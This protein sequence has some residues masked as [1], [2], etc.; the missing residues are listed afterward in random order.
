MKNKFVLGF[1][2]ISFVVLLSSCA[3]V[4]QADLDAVNA[5]IENAR[6][7]GADVYLP[8]EF[9]ALQDSMNVINQMVEAQKGKLFG[10]YK[11]VSAKI[12]DLNTAAAATKGNVETKKVE[13]KNNIDTLMVQI[14]KLVGEAK[15]LVK[16]APRG[17]E[18]A[19]AVDA[20]KTEIG[21]VETSLTESAAKLQSG[22]L[23]GTLDQLKAGKEKITA[24]IT[25]L[26]D[27]IAKYK[28]K[29]K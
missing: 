24:L 28:G 12:A 11:A 22:D 19:A 2:V 9:A 17:K 6:T 18:G 20:I 23:M 1:V 5:A 27:V 29:K 4:P 7:A 14:T 13:V 25:E 16:V 8:G 3:K 10:S 26:N 15:D 21:V